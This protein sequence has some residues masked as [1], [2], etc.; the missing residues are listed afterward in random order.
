MSQKMWI[1]INSVVLRIY[2]VFL[3]L[4]QVP[5]TC[6]TTLPYN[7][8]VLRNL[9]FLNTNQNQSMLGSYAIFFPCSSLFPPRGRDTIAR[10]PA[11]AR[12]PC[13]SAPRRA[14]AV[15]QPS[16][17]RATYFGESHRA[18]RTAWTRAAAAC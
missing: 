7:R 14:D 16:P 13:R 3:N 11:T 18:R 5:S 10:S 4:Y 2:P 8:W 15:P 17:P 1:I 12:E 9:F 6:T